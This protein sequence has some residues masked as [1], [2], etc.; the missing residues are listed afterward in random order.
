MRDNTSL[1]LFVAALLLILCVL[2]WRSDPVGEQ[3]GPFSSGDG[4]RV[5]VTP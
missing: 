1:V 5:E 4:D 2:V 3:L